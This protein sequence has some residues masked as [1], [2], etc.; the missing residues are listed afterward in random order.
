MTTDKEVAESLIKETYDAFTVRC[1]RC[2]EVQGAASWAVVADLI[3]AEYQQLGEAMLCSKCSP[4]L[5]ALR[6]P[7]MD[8]IESTSK[9]LSKQA[10]NL[11]I[12]EINQY[13]ID[14]PLGSSV[15]RLS[16]VQPKGEVH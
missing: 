3:L 14:N 1:S 13:H 16:V 6:E 10:Y 5:I 11:A 2:R 12:D 15:P 8:E 9:A 4:I 7:L